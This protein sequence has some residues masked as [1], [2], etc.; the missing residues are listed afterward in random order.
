MLRGAR[1]AV[2]VYG[3]GI[4]NKEDPKLVAS[5][6][7]LASLT[8]SDGLKVTSVKPGANSRGS[9]ESGAASRQGLAKAAPRLVYVLLGDGEVRDGDWMPLAEQAEF[10]VVQASYASP[11]TEA[12]DLVLPS[13]IWAE[14]GGT[15]VSLDGKVGHSQAVVEPPAGIKDDV[16]IIKELAGRLR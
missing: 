15:Y 5:L 9:W 10:L 7:E 6:L 12:A 11:L 3:D 4:L 16:G 14:R 13:P 8:N 1:K 2:V